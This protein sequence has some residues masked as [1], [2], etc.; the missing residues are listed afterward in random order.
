VKT[1][2]Y[3]S[4]PPIMIAID[5]GYKDIVKLLLEHKELDIN[6]KANSGHTPL[7]KYFIGLLIDIPKA[8]AVRTH[9]AFLG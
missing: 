6:E 9:I 2:E 7:S 4:D 5:C 1:S 8:F 3:K